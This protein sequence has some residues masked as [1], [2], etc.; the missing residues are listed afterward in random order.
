MD[1]IRFIFV[2]YIRKHHL[3]ASF[4]SYSL[5]N[6]ST[7]SHANIRFD[8]KRHAAANI[9]FRVNI[10]LR[11]SHTGE[12]LLAISHTSEYSLLIALNYLGKPFTSLRPQ[13]KGLSYEIDFEN[14]DEN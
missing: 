11:F 6:I 12:Y 3:F 14:V 5:Q 7:D 9:R 1:L 8:A 2:Q 4:S 13:L 10:Q